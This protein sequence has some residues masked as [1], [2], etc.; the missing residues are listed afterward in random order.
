M[1]TLKYG[2]IK[3]NSRYIPNFLKKG[4]KNEQKC[5]LNNCVYIISDKPVDIIFNGKIFVLESGEHYIPN[6]HVFSTLRILSDHAEVYDNCIVDTH[7]HEVFRLMN[8]YLV[9]I[10]TLHNNDNNLKVVFTSGMCGSLN[11]SDIE[12]TS[13]KKGNILEDFNLNFFDYYQYQYRDPG[14]YIHS[15]FIYNTDVGIVQKDTEVTKYLEDWDKQFVRESMPPCIAIVYK[16]KNFESL[17]NVLKTKY[18]ITLEKCT[19]EVIKHRKMKKYEEIISQIVK[20]NEKL[21]NGSPIFE[22]ITTRE[23][24]FTLED[25]NKIKEKYP[26]ELPPGDLIL[27]H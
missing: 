15:R 21:Q 6:F 24:P 5:N 8:N 18:N 14:E 22:F 13:N 11:D 2:Y 16:G 17:K 26:D 7:Y 19:P 25:Y 12:R 3:F 27:I 23:I 9:Y 10:D 20:Y 4:E 1:E